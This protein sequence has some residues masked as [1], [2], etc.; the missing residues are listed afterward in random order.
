MRFVRLALGG[1][2]VVVLVVAGGGH[3]LVS[4]VVGFGLVGY[5]AWRAWPAVRGDLRRL[6]SVGG[7]GRFSVASRGGD[8]LL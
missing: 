7:R 5:L 2:V 4:A 6:G 8:G 1:A 3:G